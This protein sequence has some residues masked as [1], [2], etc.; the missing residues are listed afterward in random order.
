MRERDI[1]TAEVATLDFF[2]RS[3]WDG[4]LAGVDSLFLLFPL[5]G[6]KAAR[7]AIIPFIEAAGQAAAHPGG[8][9]P[10]KRVA[11]ARPR[12]DLTSPSQERHL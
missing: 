2:D 10:R 9:R 11:V 12:V 7:E 8:V 6:N 4:A 1:G 5:P 3:T